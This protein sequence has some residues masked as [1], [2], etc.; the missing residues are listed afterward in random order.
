[1]NEDKTTPE[2][3]IIGNVMPSGHNVGN[4]RPGRNIAHDYVQSRLSGIYS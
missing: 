2:L 3:K 4:I 1:M